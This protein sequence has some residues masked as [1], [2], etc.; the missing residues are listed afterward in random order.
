MEFAVLDQDIF[1][2]AWCV[3]GILGKVVTKLV[4]TELPIGFLIKIDK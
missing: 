1:R 4:N 2:G 3:N